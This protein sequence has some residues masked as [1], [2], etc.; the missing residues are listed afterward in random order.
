MLPSF[1]KLTY[2]WIPSN[3]DSL[4]V[5]LKT[6]FKTHEG[7]EW[8]VMPIGL[9]NA[10]NIFMHLMNE[11][12]CLFV[13]SCVAVYFDDI[14]A[15]S[16]DIDSYVEDLGRVLNKLREEKLCANAF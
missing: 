10:P 16:K 15:Y 8:L 14:L 5:E 4:W 6:A 11:T 1:L 7:L 13:G 2:E 12:L 9:S 3:Q